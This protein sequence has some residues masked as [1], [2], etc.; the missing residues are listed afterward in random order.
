VKQAGDVEAG[1][2]SQTGRG[3]EKRPR[4]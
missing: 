1:L 4:I 2:P 3:G